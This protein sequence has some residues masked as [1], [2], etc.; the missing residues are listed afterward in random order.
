MAR[1]ALAVF[2]LAMTLGAQEKPVPEKPSEP[3]PGQR[4]EDPGRP[5]LRRG[6]PA[7]RSVP[8][9][10]SPERKTSRLPAEGDVVEVD[11]QGRT[12]A[13]TS[14][15][16]KPPDPHT[17]IIERAR[18][19]AF[20]FNEGL[21]NFVCDE[22]VTRYESKTLKPD[23]KYLD[24]LQVE[25]LYMGGK[26]EYRN[27]KRNGKLLKKGEEAEKS[28]S[29]S[30]GEFGSILMDIM[31]PATAA[32][33]KYRT[34]SSI[35]SIAVKVYDFRVEQLR[36]RWRIRYGPE[37]KPAYKG[38]LWIDPE[39][40][41][42]I[43]IEMDSKELPKGYEIDKVET[44][45]DYGWVAVGSKK[46]LLP[47][48]SEN[49]ACWRDSFTCTRNVLEFRNYRKFDVESQILTSDS[50]ISFPEAEEEKGAKKGEYTPPTMNPEAKTP[51]AKA[52]AKKK[53]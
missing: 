52:P 8:V 39:T 12:V 21:P 10:P 33:F 27:V 34:S 24:R 25:L 28:G 49:L 29:W 23:W 9:A 15:S 41:R 20:L 48:R 45:V 40:A 31:D 32:A 17:E 5:V 43:R 51:A 37:V 19:A 36:S 18:E 26:E 14:S 11:E 6:G 3:R 38:S 42:V 4:E 35:E 22:F 16:E 53:Q 44:V 47:T 50:D 7:Q 13:R 2:A 30:T 46:F 1:Y